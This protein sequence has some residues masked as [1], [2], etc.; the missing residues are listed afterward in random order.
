LKKLNGRKVIWRW[1]AIKDM[2]QIIVV[3]HSLKLPRG[4][5]AA[6]V[7]QAVVAAFINAGDEARRAC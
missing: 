7:A 2:N 6:Q 4:K 1:V 5:L 3:N